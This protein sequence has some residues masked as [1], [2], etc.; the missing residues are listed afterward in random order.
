MR[1]LVLSIAVLMNGFI[2]AQDS[3]RTVQL[4]EIAIRAVRASEDAP[5]AQTNISL[6]QIK[7]SY[8]G[9]HPIFMLDKLTPGFYSYSESGSS[10][11]N[12]GQF[13]MR[14]INQE[15]INITLNGVPLNDMIDQGVFFS[16]P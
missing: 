3:I 7:K 4:E 8:T 12:Y 13:R 1:K 11:A 14:G 2:Y 6:E 15:R 9:Q 16:R 10:F 5:I